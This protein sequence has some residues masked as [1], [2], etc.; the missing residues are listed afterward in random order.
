MRTEM[1]KGKQIVRSSERTSLA[2]EVLI[3][4]SQR[5]IQRKERRRKKLRRRSRL[6]MRRLFL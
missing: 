5:L 4:S 1:A 2:R 6:A 3:P